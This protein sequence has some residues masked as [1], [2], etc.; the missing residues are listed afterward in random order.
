MLPEKFRDTDADFNLGMAVAGVQV[1]ASG[2]Y[3]CLYGRLQKWEEF[4][5]K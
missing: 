5:N 2:V 3:V 4:K 1:L